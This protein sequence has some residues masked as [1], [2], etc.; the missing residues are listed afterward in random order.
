MKKLLSYLICISI[1]VISCNPDPLIPGNSGTKEELGTINFSF[2]YKVDGLQDSRIKRLSLRMAY[3][4]DSLNLGLFF[5]S[6]NVSDVVSKY[7]F[8][9]PEGTYYYQATI[10]CLC[11]LDSCKFYGFSG[12]YGIKA[13]GTKIEVFKN[14]TTEVTTQFH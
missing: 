10:M 11:K 3:T 9:L 14:Q 6:T 12:Q 4:E 7:Q 5:T 8:F 2:I 1:L 13:A